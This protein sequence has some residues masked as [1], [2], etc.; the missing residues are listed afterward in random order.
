MIT[1]TY[2]RVFI[3]GVV[4]S[5][6]TLPTCEH[7]ICRDTHARAH[8]PVYILRAGDGKSGEFQWSGRKKYATTRTTPSKRNKILTWR[9][10]LMTVNLASLSGFAALSNRDMPAGQSHLPAACSAHS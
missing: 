5:K 2:L 7:T 3:Q 10:S 1:R 4:R 8:M 9:N 6:R